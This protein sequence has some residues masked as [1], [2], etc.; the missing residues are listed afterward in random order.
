MLGFDLHKEPYYRVPLNIRG[1]ETA[2]L[3]EDRDGF[4]L[5]GQTG[6]YLYDRNLKLTDSITELLPNHAPANMLCALHDRNGNLWIGTTR[7]GIRQIDPLTGKEAGT[8]M[9]RP[10]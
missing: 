6:L 1:K 2:W 9:I 4:F 10:A 8:W 3:Y 7:Y 5:P